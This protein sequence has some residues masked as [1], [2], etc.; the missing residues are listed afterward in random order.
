[1][2]PFFTSH[3][4][5][6]AS[7]KTSLGARSPLPFYSDVASFLYKP[8]VS[9]GQSS[10]PCYTLFLLL[11]LFPLPLL[12]AVFLQ[13]G[14]GSLPSDFRR[15]VSVFSPP[16]LIPLALPPSVL[17][18][19]LFR[20]SCLNGSRSSLQRLTAFA[21]LFVFPPLCDRKSFFLSHPSPNASF[22]RSFSGQ[23][24]TAS[25]SPFL[26]ERSASSLILSDFFSVRWVFSFLSIREPHAARIE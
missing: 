4:F 7:V 12:C 20:Q 19:G 13:S 24:R 22:G 14:H 18:S 15:Q 5:I 1:L 8:A 17:R 3:L 21:Y 11:I 16:P 26:P 25:P 9:A 23:A 6:S 10:A 2:P